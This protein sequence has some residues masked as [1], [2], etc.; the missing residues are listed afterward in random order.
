MGVAWNKENGSSDS[1]A[2]RERAYAYIQHVLCAEE[3][4]KICIWGWITSEAV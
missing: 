4:K 1:F 3:E 2:G